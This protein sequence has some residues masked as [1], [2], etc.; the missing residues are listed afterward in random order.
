[1]KKVLIIANTSRVVGRQ[2]LAGA[3]RYISAFARWQVHTRPPEYLSSHKNPVFFQ[4]M[5]NFD[6][7]F[8]CDA[9]NIAQIMAASIPKVAH[10]SH[11]EDIAGACSIITNSDKIG[12]M[13]A[14]YFLSLG[15]RNFAYCGFHN[16]PW[17]DRRFKSF[18]GYLLAKGVSNIF[19]YH[20][21][22]SSSQIEQRLKIA[23]WLKSLPKPVCVF[24]CN[25]DRAV[26]LLEACK[27]GRIN[28]PEEVAVM[29]VDNDELV[30]NLSSPPLSSVLLDFETAG[31]NAAKQLDQ[32]MAGRQ[33][34]KV[35]VVEPVEILK[36]RSTDILATDD[37]ELI[38]AMIFIR[39]N[40]HKPIQVSHVVAATNLSRRELEY[41]FG[42]YL[43]K[44]IKGQIDRFRLEYITKKLRNSN[45]SIRII[46]RELE[47]TD[48]EHF[49]RYFKSM[50]GISP[51]KF[52]KL[53]T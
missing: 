28:V 12:K 34:D 7:L 2:L 29:G 35:I 42:Q 22:Q 32:L 47:F 33:R 19:E 53:R 44:T 24:A 52:R 41:R 51:L 14:D 30:C 46:A 50:T 17:S 23:Q 38:A 43:R 36:R 49:S 21:A 5:R 6:G 11:K 27:I 45:D 8:V 15:F 13:V 37:K 9:R 48:A 16:L 4:D 20:Y 1:M 26:Y 40:F 31:F 25:D 39:N 10:Y 18:S 3:E